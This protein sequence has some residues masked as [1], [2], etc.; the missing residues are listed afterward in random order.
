M[1]IWVATRVKINS[2]IVFGYPILTYGAEDLY[3]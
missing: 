2:V 1:V 3:G